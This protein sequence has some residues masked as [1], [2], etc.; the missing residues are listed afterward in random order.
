VQPDDYR[1]QRSLMA[2][3]QVAARMGRTPACTVTVGKRSNPLRS[4]AIRIPSDSGEAPVYF[5]SRH[6][7]YRNKWIWIR[8]L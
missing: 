6:L 2:H 7:E 1:G 8:D 5:L 4:F 3:P